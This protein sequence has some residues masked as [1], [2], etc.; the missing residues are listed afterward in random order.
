MRSTKFSGLAAQ[1]VVI[2]AV[3]LVLALAAFAVLEWQRSARGEL[4]SMREA[5]AVESALRPHNSLKEDE[6]RNCER[7]AIKLACWVT[8]EKGLKRSWL[9]PND[10]TSDALQ[11]SV[12]PAQSAPA[13]SPNNSPWP[14]FKATWQHSKHWLR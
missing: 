11:Q 10:H 8:G 5:A 9:R 13:E 7:C 14:R 1:R 3:A 2:S 4:I 6:S 12:S